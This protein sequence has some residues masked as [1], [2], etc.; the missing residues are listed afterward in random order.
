VA[1]DDVGVGDGRLGAALSVRG[2]ARLGAGRLRADAQR[3]GQ[4]RDVGD[5]AAAGADRVHVHRRHLDPE[6]A[7]RGLAADRRLAVLA[8]GDVGGRAAHVER[9]DVVEAG[10]A[11]DEQRP[12]DT[13][14][15]TGEHTVDRIARRLPRRHQ[16]GVG[17][18]DVHV[19]LGADPAQLL[20]QPVDVVRHF[21]AHVRVHA[22]GQ[23]AL[24]LAELGE[25]LRRERDREARV[26]ALDDLP[27]LA[28]V[29]AV[30]VRVDQRHRQRLDTRL[31]QVADD[32]L[33][34][35]DVDRDDRLAAGV[36]SLDRL[37]CV[38]QRRG[39][40]GLDH[41]DPTGERPRRL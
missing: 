1:E 5:R 14:G 15:R 17:A 8:E 37:T 7:N 32:A 4:L 16:P 39:R 20:L 24:V 29:R 22:G 19:R 28:L 41:D 21:R 13:S 27:D 33:D 26:E 6:V 25:D 2:R 36:H 38:G 35:P 31:D 9:E 12:R 40:V 30:H 3:P 10:L 18:E 23:R 34:L 11:C